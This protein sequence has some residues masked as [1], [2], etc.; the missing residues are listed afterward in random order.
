[1]VNKKLFLMASDSTS[2]LS[3]LLQS[4][5]S[6]IR[7]VFNSNRDEKE[8]EDWMQTWSTKEENGILH[9][10]IVSEILSFVDADFLFGRCT[11]VC[12]KWNLIVHEMKSSVKLNNI[13]RYWIQ[14]INL[15]TRGKFKNIAKC[16]VVSLQE[17][18]LTKLFGTE[19]TWNNLECLILDK[20]YGFCV[21]ECS[22]LKL[23]RLASL[24]ITRSHANRECIIELLKNFPKLERLDCKDTPFTGE[25]LKE[26]CNVPI[27]ESFLTI[28]LC[29]H[30][31]H[32]ILNA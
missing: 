15:I 9:S 27:W 29:I 32:V 22:A 13:D 14:H 7:N 1:M 24:S 21:S 20:C 2:S 5:Y 3:S 6:N 30:D 10:D 19:N 18:D 31:L 23:P 4:A 17:G 12:I 26:I 8:E 28:R 25:H 16:Q 11:R